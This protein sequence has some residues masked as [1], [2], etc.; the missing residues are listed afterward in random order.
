MVMLYVAAVVVVDAVQQQIRLSVQQRCV[1]RMKQGEQTVAEVD[2]HDAM[3]QKEEDG[4]RKGKVAYGVIEVEVIAADANTLLQEDKAAVVEATDAAEIEGEKGQVQHYRRR[5]QLHF[6]I[7]QQQRDASS[8]LLSSVRSF[9]YCNEKRN[10]IASI[11]LLQHF[12][13]SVQLCCFFSCC[14]SCSMHASIAPATLHTHT[15]HRQHFCTL[16]IHNLNV[17][18]MNQKRANAEEGVEKVGDTWT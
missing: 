2:Q 5:Q 13:P 18:R 11:R 16:Q 7:M 12:Q 15:T 14:T 10:S 4:V 9:K 3:Q 8:I 6:E 1:Q 17:C